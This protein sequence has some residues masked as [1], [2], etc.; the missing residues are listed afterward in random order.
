[1]LILFNIKLKYRG[2]AKEAF[3]DEWIYIKPLFVVVPCHTGSHGLTG[4]VNSYTINI[5]KQGY[6]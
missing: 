6:L 3:L 2:Y 5:V 4:V 1:M